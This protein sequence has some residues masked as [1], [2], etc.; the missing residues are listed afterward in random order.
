MARAV[1]RAH[2]IAATGTS[3]IPAVALAIAGPR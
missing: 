1:K 3:T 2:D